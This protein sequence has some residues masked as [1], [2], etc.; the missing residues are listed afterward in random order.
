MRKSVEELFWRFV[1]RDCTKSPAGSLAI[2]ELV[3]SQRRLHLAR[4][5][6]DM[7]KEERIPAASGTSLEYANKVTILKR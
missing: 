6:E 1:M 3:E 4:V 2:T 5:A 7:A